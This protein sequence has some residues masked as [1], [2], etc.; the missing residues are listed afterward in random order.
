MATHFCKNWL[1]LKELFFC[2]SVREQDL[3][4]DIQDMECAVSSPSSV[5]DLLKDTTLTQDRTENDFE[6]I[7]DC[8]FDTDLMNMDIDDLNG[9]VFSDFWDV[10]DGYF[11]RGRLSHSRY[12]GGSLWWSNTDWRGERWFRYSTFTRKDIKINGS[13][14]S[15]FRVDF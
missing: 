14:R 11:S 7:S 4:P 5:D 6:D 9:P 13:E 1:K 8:S 2:F 15:Y 12:T 10:A 3:Y